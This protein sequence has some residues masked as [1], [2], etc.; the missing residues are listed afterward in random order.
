MDTSPASSFLVTPGHPLMG[1]LRLPGDKSLSHRAA[2][3]ASLA[4]G[5][6]RVENFLVAGVTRAMLQALEQLGVAWNLDGS[7]L[8]V[9]GEGISRFGGG[10]E[11]IPHLDC[12]NSATTLRLLAGS[13][14]AS[15]AGAVLDGSEGLRRRPMNRIVDP[16]RKMGVRIQS[17][18]GRAP[19]RIEPAS[20]PLT[21]VEHELNVASAQVKSCLLLAGLSADGPVVVREP[22]PSRDHTER[23]LRSMGV[24]VTGAV[25]T[26]PAGR[27]YETWLV[28]P[29]GPLEPLAVSLPGD[30]SAAAFL[31]VAATITP[32][33]EI[34]L[35]EV[36]L[37]PTR[38]GLLDALIEMGADI[39]VQP[40]GERAGEPA[41]DILVC[42]ADLRGCIVEGDR[43]VRMIDEFPAFAVAAAF[44]QGET[45]VRNARELRYK[46]S[47]R[48]AAIVK[49]LRLL[50][51][52]IEERPDGFALQ[53]GRPLKGARVHAHGDHRLAMSLAVAGLAT[54][55][56]VEVLG[57]E[58]IQESFP[59]FR[60]ALADLGGVFTG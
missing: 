30:F 32:G 26:T 50:G 12:G 40:L 59:G 54:E 7:T 13:I 11:E 15:G 57:A 29:E 45:I 5:A 23:M 39:E 24:Q 14:A 8:T 2:L 55:S 1:E 16:L 33:S 60:K 18:G 43:V 56:P 10:R 44:A 42:H 37:N 21:A 47:D 53:G 20:L 19:L 28:P 49:E 31:I 25:Q 17:T 58:M 46:E 51:V 35:L 34:R 36:G 52:H 48:I 9:S 38:T 27:V 22:G 3:F 4:E 41:G 6:S